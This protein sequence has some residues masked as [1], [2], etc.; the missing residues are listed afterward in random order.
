MSAGLGGTGLVADDLYLMAH[1]EVNGK[2]FVQPRALGSGLAGGLLAEL[3]LGGSVILRYDGALVAGHIVPRDGLAYQVL[4]QITGEHEAHPV[5]EW[6]LFLARTASEDVA[7]RLERS[8]YV[9]RAGATGPWGPGRAGPVASGSWGSDG[10]RLGVLAAAAR[11]FRAGSRPAFRGPKCRPGWASCRVRAGLP[12]GAVPAPTRPQPG[13]G[14]RAARSRRPGADRPDPG[15]YRQRRACS[16]RV[17]SI[18]TQGTRRLLYVQNAHGRHQAQQ[19]VAG[20]GP[21]PAGRARRTVLRASWRRAAD[22]GGRGDPH[23]V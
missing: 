22:R 1:H 19:R 13:G 18:R 10:C 9:T 6:L 14:I 4:G 17:N 23:R 3:M 5:R 2:P 12:P 7:R 15:G 21:R 20:A 16:S 8:G 11:A